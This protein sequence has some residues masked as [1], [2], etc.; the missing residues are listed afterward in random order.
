[1]PEVLFSE[2]EKVQVIPPN[3]EPSLRG[4]L[5]PNE[6]DLSYSSPIHLTAGILVIR[7]F[8]PTK[9]KCDG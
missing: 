2:I 4:K 5:P 1:M 9:G 7:Q 3:T 8:S 6:E